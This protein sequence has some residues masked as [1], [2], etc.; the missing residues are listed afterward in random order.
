MGVARAA[1]ARLQHQGGKDT[2]PM[3]KEMKAKLAK[4]KV[5]SLV[6]EDRCIDIYS[7]MYVCIILLSLLLFRIK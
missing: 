2:L 5:G 1:H 3:T 7:Y 6:V 4:E